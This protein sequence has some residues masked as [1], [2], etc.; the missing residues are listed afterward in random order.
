M[1][2]KAR[3]RGPVRTLTV[4]GLLLVLLFGGLGAAAVWAPPRQRSPRCSA[5]T[6]PA[7]GRS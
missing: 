2:M 7:A 3:N 6:S 1:A 5:S 4:L